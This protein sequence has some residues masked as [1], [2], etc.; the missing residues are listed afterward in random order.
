MGCLLRHR[1]LVDVLTVS[2]FVDGGDLERHSF[3][4]AAAD[5]L[6]R[7]FGDG[8]SMRFCYS[9]YSGLISAI[10]RLDYAW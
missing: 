8:L 2:S 4:V 9:C 3:A 10:L 1:V 7:G 6:G 5:A